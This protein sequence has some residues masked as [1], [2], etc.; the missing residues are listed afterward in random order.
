MAPNEPP[1]FDE[2]PAATR[3]VD[4][5][6]S[7]GEDIGAPVTATDPEDDTLTY[8]LDVTSRA[9]FDIVATSGQLRTK[10]AL[11]FET[12][13]NSYTVIVTAADPSG[14]DDTITVTI[15]VDNV[16]EAG[17]V[18][19]SSTQPQVAIELTAVLDDPD[20]VSGSVT[21]SWAGSSNGI[22][23]WTPISGATSAAYTPVAADVGDYLQATASYTDGEGSGK[24]AQ[25]VS[26]NR[27]QAA[28]WRRMTR[29]S[30]RPPRT[31]CATWTRT[32]HR[33]RTS[34]SPSRPP[35]T[36]TTP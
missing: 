17:T 8:S 31:V 6:T 2:S 7:A 18:T 12:G 24:S 16:D 15:T 26:T 11:D 19:L 4:E 33:A 30:S 36:T 14:A 27:V 29:P 35:T 1:A 3:D 10:A 23:S 5:N 25:A 9:T 32:P 34:A 13:T 21:W 22:S 20:G 28:R